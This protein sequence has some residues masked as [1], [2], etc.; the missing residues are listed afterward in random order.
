M[1]Q[2]LLKDGLGRFTGSINSEFGFWDE[3]ESYRDY[4]VEEVRFP[5]HGEQNKTFPVHTYFIDL[6]TG[7]VIK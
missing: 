7:E 2:A 5:K 4:K 1:R 3:Q 6:E